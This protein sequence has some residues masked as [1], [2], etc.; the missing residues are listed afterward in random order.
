MLS[1]RLKLAIAGLNHSGLPLQIS[2]IITTFT[3]PSPGLSLSSVYTASTAQLAVR[4]KM[5]L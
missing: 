5:Q 1:D 2:S 3:F 4:K